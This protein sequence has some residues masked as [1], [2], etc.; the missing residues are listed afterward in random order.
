[1]KYHDSSKESKYVTYL[2]ANNLYGWA[3]S[4]Y[5]PYSEFKWL[6]KKQIDRFDVYSTG[7]NSSIGYILEV[8][9]N[10]LSELHKLHNG[11]SLAP[12]KVEI[13]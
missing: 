1:M 5:L 10:Y 8:D 7:E 6:N 9:L 13:S 3:M 11:Y 12:E 4:Q 2:D